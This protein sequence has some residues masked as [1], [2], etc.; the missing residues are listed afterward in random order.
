MT[1]SATPFQVLLIEDEVTLR[2]SMARGLAKLEGVQVHAAASVGE[3]LAV[4]DRVC[5]SLILSD[6]DLPDRSGIELIGELAARKLQLPVVFISAYLKA[7]GNLIPRHAKVEALDKPV[8]MDELRDVV[9]RHMTGVRSVAAP[10]GV[11]DY[12]QLAAMGRYSAIIEVSGRGRI[13]V[14]EGH[15]WSA[16]DE[17]GVGP[18]AFARLAVAEAVPVLCRA[19]DC[20]AGPRELHGG[21]EEM[22]LDALRA[23]DEAAASPQGSFT[24]LELEE[25]PATAAPPAPPAPPA[26]AAAPAPDFDALLD[27]ALQAAFAK[28]HQAALALFEQAHL[29]KPE[30]RRVEVNIHRLKQLL[31]QAAEQAR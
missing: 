13:V 20:E 29:L 23:K 25:A 19:L 17:Q 28:R 14:F 18:E 26:P 9:R 27:D 15:A 8:G 30:D 16:S 22:L 11:P 6:L 2:A 3:G 31:A 21:T 7:Y 1:P 5:P 24:E 10:F 12:L 4:V